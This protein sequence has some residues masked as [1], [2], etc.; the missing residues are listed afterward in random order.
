ME[1]ESE[2]KENER[3]GSQGLQTAMIKLAFALGD[4]PRDEDWVPAK[5]RAKRE[6]AEERRGEFQ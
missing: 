1:W 4:D 2:W 6:H 3:L 5:L